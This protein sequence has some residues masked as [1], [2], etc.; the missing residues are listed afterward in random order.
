[1]QIWES[2]EVF[3][4]EIVTPENVN[5]VLAELRVSLFGHNRTDKVVVLLR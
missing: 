1:M 2:F 4:L 5:L 3:R